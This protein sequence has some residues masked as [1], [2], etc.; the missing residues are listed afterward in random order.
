M[1]KSSQ[2]SLTRFLAESGADTRERNRLLRRGSLTHV[3]DFTAQSPCSPC[4]F[5]KRKK[6]SLRAVGGSSQTGSE[7]EF[8]RAPLI[9]CFTAFCLFQRRNI[10]NDRERRPASTGKY[11]RLRP[12]HDYS[13]CFAWIITSHS[14]WEHIDNL[15][16]ADVFSYYTLS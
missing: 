2:T 3:S 1:P 9:G 16:A 8:P 12:Y 14:D 13:T 7:G 6:A 4:T 10:V 15:S 11:G 5:R